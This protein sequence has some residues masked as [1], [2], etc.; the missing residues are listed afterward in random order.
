MT[1][2]AKHEVESEIVIG[3][4]NDLNAVLLSD[5]EELES[6]PLNQNLEEV[7]RK[8]IRYT[9]GALAAFSWLLD[10]EPTPI[11]VKNLSPEASS[12]LQ[13]TANQ[14][15]PA[16]GQPRSLRRRRRRRAHG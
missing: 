11:D 10:I 16:T 14:E 3:W 8:R 9:Q 13:S 6:N 15:A 12:R 5:L 4:L 1:E 7:L 2:N